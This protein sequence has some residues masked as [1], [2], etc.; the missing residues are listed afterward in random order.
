MYSRDVRGKYM[1][2]GLGYILHL[3]GSHGKVTNMEKIP[4]QEGI[5]RLGLRHWGPWG[6]SD[7]TNPHLWTLPINWMVG[8]LDNPGDSR[9]E[10]GDVRCKTGLPREAH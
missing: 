7:H 3:G 5:P 10:V 1:Y 8:G 6:A 4:A 9:S 2:Y